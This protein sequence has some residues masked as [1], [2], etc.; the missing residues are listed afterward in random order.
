MGVFQLPSALSNEWILFLYY[1]FDRIYR[2]KWIFSRFPEETL[3]TES[4]HLFLI[5]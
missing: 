4:I 3:K 1:V 5:S 2:I